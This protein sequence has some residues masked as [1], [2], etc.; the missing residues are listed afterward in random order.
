MRVAVLILCFL[1]FSVPLQAQIL[2]LVVESAEGLD[3][4]VE[5]KFWWSSQQALPAWTK[6]DEAIREVARSR[7]LTLAEPRDVSQISR[8]HRRA[9]LT[10]AAALALASVFGA[11]EILL[12]TVEISRRTGPL[13]L[14]GAR[15]TLRARV[16]QPSS[17]G[18]LETKI[19]ELSRS[20]FETDALDAMARVRRE[21]GKGLVELLER[22]TH[23]MKMEVGLPQEN[24]PYLGI[25]NATRGIWLHHIRDA[26]QKVSGVEAVWLGWA[27]EGL[28][29]LSLEGVSDRNL[30]ERVIHGLME[31]SF[32]DFRLERV[33]SQFPGVV[34]LRVVEGP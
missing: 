32:E 3:G 15:G 22:A 7:N 19:I 9:E 14:K 17:D 28:V 33:E 29:A 4:Q 11:D 8:V 13:G 23:D 24:H 34:E 6:T 26:A 1:A 12:G 20:A 2:P 25:R 30:I 5:T 21:L 31:E 10:P 16:I 27:T 18:P